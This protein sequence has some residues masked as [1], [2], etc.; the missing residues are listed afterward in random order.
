M[1]HVFALILYWSF[2]VY[3]S[4]VPLDYKALPLDQAVLHF[5]NIRYLD[6]GIQSRADWVA[7]ILLYIPLP[8]LLFSNLRSV[9]KIGFISKAIVSILVFCFCIATAIGVEFVQQFFPPRTVSLN[10]LI[11][12]MIGTVIGMILWFW[13]GEKSIAYSRQMTQGSWVSIKAAIILYLPIYIFLSLFPFDFVTSTSELNHKLASG[14]D[15]FFIDVDGCLANPFRC[16]VKWFVEMLVLMP[17]G[18]L[19]AAL[20]YVP[21]RKAL[22]VVVGFLLGLLIEFTQVFIYSGSAQGFSIVTRMLGM[23]VGVTAYNFLAGG[24]LKKF[25]PWLGW[26]IGLSLIPYL[27]AVAAVNGWMEGHW[28]SVAA[29]QQKL[30][31]THFLPFY[32][33]YYT[34]ETVA[35]V[36]LLSNIGAY[37]PV[38]V[39]FWLYGLKKTARQKIHGFWVGFTAALLAVIMETGKLFLQS[40]HVD[41]TDVLIAFFAG[42]GTYAILNKIQI[43]LSRSESNGG[44]IYSR[45]AENYVDGSVQYSSA[46]KV[47]P[48]QKKWLLPAGFIAILITYQLIQYPLMPSFLAVFVF[49]YAYALFR[50]PLIGLFAL[51]AL[52][53]LMDFAPWTGRFF[54]D[55]F[56]LIVLSTIMAFIISPTLYVE[57]FPV[58]RFLDY[59]IVGLFLLLLGISLIIGLTPFPEID[60][61]SFSNYYSHYNAIRVAKGF[62][63]GLLLSPYLIR[64]LRTENGRKYFT[65][66]FLVGLGGL[67]IFSI[68]ER[69]VFPGLFDFSTDYRINGLFSTM[70]TGGGHIESYLALTMPFIAVLVLSD[71]RVV[72]ASVGTIL[73]FALSLYT[74]LMTFSRGGVIG[75]AVG[76]LVLLVGI[77]WHFSRLHQFKVI[78]LLV[79]VALSSAIV[80]TLAIPVFKGDLMQQRISVAEK[81]SQT[82][83]QHLAAAIDMMD[84]DIVTRLF[85]MGLGSF[86]RTF[87]WS[88][89]EDAHPATYRINSEDS[90]QYLALQGGDALFMGQYISLAPNQR[91]KLSMDVRSPEQN[92]T[93]SVPICEKSLQYSFRCV[94]VEI[95]VAS[96]QWQHVEKEI[97]N[98]DVGAASPDI[99]GGWLTRPVQLA[100]YAGGN[101]Q[102]IVEVDNLSLLDAKGKNL[103][104]NGDFSAG[105]DRWYFSTEKHNP[106]HIFNIWVHVLFDMGWFGLSAFVLLMAYVYYRLLKSLRHDMYAPV[107]LS[108]FTGFLIIGYVDSP[109]DAPRLSFL[110]FMLVIFAIFGCKRPD[111]PFRVVSR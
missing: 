59:F 96:T 25:K 104:A 7:N 62:L 82:R 70:H 47:L 5:K 66:G 92:A 27:L 71:K 15:T 4:L 89:Q 102:K 68:F 53:P 103:I 49:G 40:K 16:A 76:F 97:D 72:L 63:W 78:P 38:G 42:A 1:P 109:F 91:M 6:L 46:T 50:N 54:F 26:V 86:P 34:T 83:H 8:F 64:L 56:D 39:L 77:F 33:F 52:L 31:Q 106:W 99:A 13:V 43:S 84:S 19:F 11:A 79:V 17:L 9:L 24:N 108:S 101:M 85:G 36:S 110:F 18:A 28:I 69:W 3:G 35:L 14:H 51:P 55:E 95:D 94:S 29:A 60:P 87:Y 98:A 93:L 65:S 81:D 41:P 74:L 12:E 67:A 80:A 73:L 105:T 58:F 21:N 44:D 75:V 90:N 45:N 88:N 32:Y 22:A 10:D 20:P 23:T 37:M 30:N 48:G 2:I 111:K 57:R 100:L 61:N 107:L